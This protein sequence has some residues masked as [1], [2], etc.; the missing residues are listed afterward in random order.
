[1]KVA[2]TKILMKTKRART[3]SMQSLSEHKRS[4]ITKTDKEQFDR[5]QRAYTFTQELATCQESDPKAVYWA[6]QKHVQVTAML[7]AWCARHML[8]ET[9]ARITD[10][11]TWERYDAAAGA[12]G[13]AWLNNW[14]NANP[15]R[16]VE[17]MM[18]GFKCCAKGD[19][20]MNDVSRRYE[21]YAK[22]AGVKVKELVR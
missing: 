14:Q 1:M 18:R 12:A 17:G 4:Q 5:I 15:V 6:D 13:K 11:E 2:A 20:A 19:G 16:D 10:R 8:T 9:A 22:A 21:G 7:D 3:L